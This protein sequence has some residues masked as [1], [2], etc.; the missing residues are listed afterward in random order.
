[1]TIHRQLFRFAVVGLVSNVLLYLAYLL[2]TALGVGHKTVMTVLYITGVCMTFVLNRN[3][4]FTHDGHVTRAFLA[5]V[6][7]YAFGYLVNFAVLYA[8]VDRLGYDHRI[9]QGTMI[10]CL[11]IFFFLS[12]KFLVFRSR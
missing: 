2:I 11:A 8:L 7:L 10:V 5:Y 6:A 4:T 12:Q 3:W 1:M 9:V